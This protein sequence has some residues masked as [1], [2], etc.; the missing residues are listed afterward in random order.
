V[1]RAFEN[2]LKLPIRLLQRL[3]PRP[4]VDASAIPPDLLEQ[5]RGLSTL[6]ADDPLFA[7]FAEDYL[8]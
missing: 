1:K 3:S 4:P 2:R 6:L 8:F 5:F 7:P